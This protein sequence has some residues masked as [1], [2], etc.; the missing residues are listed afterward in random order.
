MGGRRLRLLLLLFILVVLTVLAAASMGALKYKHT[1]EHTRL[2]TK[3]KA[4][5]TIKK[6]QLIQLPFF[7]K[8]W[9]R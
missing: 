8:I 2:K 3:K 4:T 6:G 7:V 1:R 9:M 5:L